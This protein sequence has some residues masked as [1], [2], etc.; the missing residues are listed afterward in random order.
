MTLSPRRLVP[1]CA[2]VAVLAAA[3]APPAPAASNYCSPTGDYCY[4]ASKR[5]P[6]RL[7]I[8]LAAKY[9]ETYRLCVTGPDGVRDCKRFRIRERAD[10]V[11]VG[12][13]RWARHFPNRGH[14]TYRVRWFATGNA[15]G[16]GVTFR[17]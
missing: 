12:K 10:G 11:P 15:L 5:A 13:V 17:R 7:T 2:A 4:G 16:P 6:V 3:A 1:A 14:G 9:F 8:A